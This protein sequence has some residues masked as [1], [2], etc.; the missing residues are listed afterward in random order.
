MKSAVKIHATLENKSEPTYVIHANLHPCPIG[1]E[2]T[3]APPICD[4][5]S[6]VRMQYLQCDI[7]RPA[8]KW[9]GFTRNISCIVLHDHCPFDY[10]KPAS[11]YINLSTPDEQ[12]AFNHSG[13][14]CGGCQEGLS[15]ALG[16]SRCLQCSN[17]YLLLFIRFLLAGVA[18]VFLL[19]KCNLDVSVGT[20]NGLIFYAN[21]V[22]A[23]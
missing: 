2:L 7:L 1:F 11:V 4:C 14:L 12:C 3:G 19:L 18:L 23:N 20:I 17:V 13:I 9:I 6:F 8:E 10:C 15:L 22:W 21:I 5:A 16:S